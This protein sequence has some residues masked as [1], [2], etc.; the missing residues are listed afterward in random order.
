MNSKTPCLSDEALRSCLD[1]SYRGGDPGAAG[2]HVLGCAPCRGRAERMLKSETRFSDVRIAQSVAGRSVNGSV[3][4]AILRPSPKPPTIAPASVPPG[5]PAGGLRFLDPPLLDHPDDLGLFDRYRIVAKLGQGGMGMVFRAVDTTLDRTVALKI[6]LPQYAGDEGLRERFLQEA[7]ATVKVRSPHVAEVYDCGVWNDVPFLTMELLVGVT[8]D[9]KS[10]PMALDTWRRIAFG[11]A[12]GLA[13]A[14]R[15]G[16]IHRDL[17]PGNIHLGTDARTNKPTVKIIDFGLARPVD[18]KVEMTKSGVM[19]G[20]PAYM[21]LEQA[22]GEKVDHR[23]DLYSLGVILYQL[24]TG[25][26]PYSNTT[27]VMAILTELA[28]PGRLPSVALGA[29]D[30]PPSLVE[31][32]DGLLEKEAKNRPA[33]ADEVMKALKASRGGDATASAVDV[34]VAAESPSVLARAIVVRPEEKTQRP[35][36]DRTLVEPMPIAERDRTPRRRRR[37][38]PV[39]RSPWFWPAIFGGVGT[40]AIV[41]I[42]FAAGAFQG[43]TGDPVAQKAPVT[44]PN[45]PPQEPG[46]VPVPADNRPGAPGA[47]GEPFRNE[48]PAAPDEPRPVFKPWTELTTFVE[49]VPRWKALDAAKAGEIRTNRDTAIK[50]SESFEATV[51]TQFMMQELMKG[52][53]P[54]RFMMGPGMQPAGGPPQKLLQLKVPNRFSLTGTLAAIRTSNDK[55]WIAVDGGQPEFSSPFR[56][57]LVEFPLATAATLMADY[58]AGDRVRIAARRSPREEYRAQ[59][60]PG[61]PQGIAELLLEQR[62]VTGRSSFPITYWAFAGEGIELIDQN[63]SW[64]DPVRGRASVPENAAELARAP[65]YLLRNQPVSIGLTG[66]LTGTVRRK[67]DGRN[68]LPVTVTV[69]LTP[70]AEGSPSALLRMGALVTSAELYDYQAGDVIEAE[71]TLAA[72]PRPNRPVAMFPGPVGPNGPM[73][74][75]G[76]P[77]EDFSIESDLNFDCVRLQKMQRPDTLVAASGPRRKVQID[78]K[79]PLTPDAVAVAPAELLDREVTWTGK[80]KSVRAVDGATHVVVTVPNPKDGVDEF[81]AYADRAWLAQLVDYIATDEDSSKA[82]TV[83]VTGRV[84]LPGSKPNRVRD[85]AP[86]L[87]GLSIERSGSPE[88]RAAVGATRAASSYRTPARTDE[89][90]LLFRD[91]P[92]DGKEIRFTAYYQR[93]NTGDSTALL[94][95]NAASSLNSVKCKIPGLTATLLSDYRDNDPVEVVGTLLRAANASDR[96]LAFD[97]TSIVRKANARSRIT[98]K[99]REFPPL[100]FKDAYDRWSRYRSVGPMA[101]TFAAGGVYDGYTVSG[102]TLKIGLKNAFF[103]SSTLDL[104][105]PDTAV[106]RKALDA[107]KAGDEILFEGKTAMASGKLT[108]SKSSSSRQLEAVWIAPIGDPEKKVDLKPKP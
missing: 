41:A 21:S 51:L 81:E 52:G 32:V 71:V 14:H 62:F 77:P 16:M 99:G 96:Q 23:T 63:Q 57:C 102:G 10:K 68:G 30:L 27:S 8:L 94:T 31:L 38:E 100:D 80:L 89:L 108:K 105:C 58:R 13:D 59:L 69:Q 22:H 87:K 78:P 101:E 79:Q 93:F 35:R 64:I 84:A 7:Q 65:S 106:N 56:G 61:I 1:Q 67:T 36:S 60:P 9:Q 42:A 33:S 49:A 39:R 12:K 29:P 37:N 19:L 70:G 83:V 43:R 86:L 95:S 28:A 107:F 45:V 17:K 24:A 88:S 76:P 25:K 11:I 53:I 103:K 74:S 97:A 46:F 50:G 48:P 85:N 44:A 2:E 5:D 72:K 55:T 26:L 82:D 75:S 20:T 47:P 66:R 92:T 90:A 34:V 40:V 54:G 18:R 4:D 104:Y 98:D 91:P 3:V 6:I 73:S 15:S